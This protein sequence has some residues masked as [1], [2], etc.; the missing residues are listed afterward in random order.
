MGSSLPQHS[1]SPGPLASLD[2]V[3]AQL[4]GV[5][6]VD[7]GWVWG[8]P[9]FANVRVP[10]AT[11]FDYARAGATLAEFLADFSGVRAEDAIRVLDV[12]ARANLLPKGVNVQTFIGSADPRP[13][14]RLAS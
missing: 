8:Q 4:R 3:L 12:A 6:R 13:K 9:A 2:E 11:L 1:D 10:I 7:D 5:V 14:D